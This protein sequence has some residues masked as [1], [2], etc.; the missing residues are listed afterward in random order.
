MWWSLANEFDFLLDVKPIPQWDRYFH[1]IEEHDPNR[2]LASI[3]NGE[4][5]VM[6]DHRKPWVSHV[7]VQN[8]EVKKTPE[9]RR[10]WGKPLVN[11]EL[12]YEGD[13]PRPWGN[14][15][16]RELVHRFWITVLGGGYAGHGETF[17]HPDDLLWWA[18]GGSLRG[19]SAPRIKFLRK[20]IEDDGPPWTD[21]A[22]RRRALGVPPRV[23][24]TGRRRHVPLFSAN[25]NRASG[26][27]AC[28][29]GRAD[30]AIDLIDTW[31][32]SVTPIE[33]APLPVSPAL[34]QRGGAITGD[35]PEAAF[36]IRLP[37]RPQ[38]AVR[39]KPR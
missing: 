1:V 32:M 34:R 3:H 5:E 33:K 16:A 22:G 20:L 26:R 13:I 29:N 28:R 23:R 2:H 19:E 14:I 35:R 36:G 31:D 10:Q 25:I 6:F 9:W 24:R 18:K 12:E 30:Y 37:G 15:S 39:V 38:M 8:T 27:S 11:D 21:A 17:M 7:C 4:P